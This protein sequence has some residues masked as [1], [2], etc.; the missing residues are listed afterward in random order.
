MGWLRNI[1]LSA[2][3]CIVWIILCGVLIQTG[4]ELSIQKEE[5][6]SFIVKEEY[7]LLNMLQMMLKE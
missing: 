5:M 2:R 1:Q 7:R 6:Q 4:E 3:M